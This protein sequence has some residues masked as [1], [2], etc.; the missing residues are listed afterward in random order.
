[1]AIVN[2]KTVQPFH[3]TDNFLHSLFQVSHDSHSPAEDD[4][5]LKRSISFQRDF[6]VHYILKDGRLQFFGT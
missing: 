2:G 4:K 3:D 5:F 6:P 1:M